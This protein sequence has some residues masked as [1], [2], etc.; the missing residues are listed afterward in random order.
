MHLVAPNCLPR[1]AYL[2]ASQ[3]IK[4]RVYLHLK[5]CETLALNKECA[6]NVK[7]MLKTEMKLRNLIYKQLGQWLS[8]MKACDIKANFKN[9]I[10]RGSF[11]TV[12]SVQ[13]L[14]A[15]G[16]QSIRLDEA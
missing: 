3:A 4:H 14:V 1:F 6:A 13:C 2:R 12:F 9:K 11:T 7:G 5:L 10:R 8:Q 16:C 15:V